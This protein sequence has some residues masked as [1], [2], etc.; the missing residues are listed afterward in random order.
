MTTDRNSQ[1]AA[2]GHVFWDPQRR[3]LSNTSSAPY[4]PWTASLLPILHSAQKEQRFWMCHK[5]ARNVPLKSASILRSISSL[6]S[7]ELNEPMRVFGHL[8]L[9]SRHPGPWYCTYP[10]IHGFRNHLL[11]YLAS[12]I[13][14]SRCIKNRALNYVN[15]VYLSLSTTFLP[16]CFTLV[17]ISVDVGIILPTA[18]NYIDIQHTSPFDQ[19]LH[20]HKLQ[21]F[22][23]LEEERHEW[24]LLH[25]QQ[26]VCGTHTRR[27]SYN[28]TP[29]RR[30]AF[31][32]RQH[33]I[34][35]ILPCNPQ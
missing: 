23:S 35:E 4:K 9:Q 21:T 2:P 34:S 5:R 33:A 31:D 30:F 24:N 7:L 19:K 10:P 1:S 11:R 26:C 8:I 15:I 25:L 27:P 29:S 22:R 16:H 14:I 20:V 6:Q 3:H 12:P 28:K 13:C 17:R 18:T 32:Q